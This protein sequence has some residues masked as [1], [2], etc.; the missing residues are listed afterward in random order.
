MQK[1]L[2]KEKL[3]NGRNVTGCILATPSASSVEILGMLGFDY[4]FIDCE[5]SILS[6]ED[7]EH[8]IR[9]AE[10]NGITPVIRVR[11]NEPELMIRYLDAGAQGI[12]VPGVSNR[13]EAEAAVGAVR[14]Y[15]HG[16]RGL[17]PGRSSDYGM[18]LSM[19]DY[20]EYANSQMVLFTSME[21]VE[22]VENIEEILSVDGLD[23]VLFGTSDLS[24]SLGLPGQGNHPTVQAA[25]EKALI[26][27]LKTGK[28]LG[29]V[30]R[31]GETPQ[32]YFGKGYRNVLTTVNSLLI[33]AGRAF[34][35]QAKG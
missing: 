32:D 34:V 21:N 30:V 27:G 15:P 6:A 18:K 3:A 9:A 16:S 2:L 33:S 5:H 22:A 23:G 24:Q 31:A 7:C 11:K 17:S 25:V 19:K 12:V 8:L 28:P 10:L 4:V 26:N 20:V 1:N 29:S 14:Y 35:E 13:K